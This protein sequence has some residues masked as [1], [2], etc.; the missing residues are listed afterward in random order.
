MVKLVGILNFTPDSF[1]D[2]G[3]FYDVDKAMAQAGKLFDDGA[4]IVDIGGEST[5]PGATPLAADEEWQRH[6]ETAEHA[7]RLGEVIINDVTGMN[8]ADMISVVARY[9][10][11]CI[12]SHLPDTDIQ[13][14]HK[15]K[16]VKGSD[17]VIMDL[18]RREKELAAAGIPKDHIIFD[19]GIG[20]GKTQEL[21]VELLEFAGYFP[22]REVMIGYSK[23]SFLGEEQYDTQVNLDAGRIAIAAG[24]AYLR[25][26]DVAAHRALL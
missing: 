17:T 9:G 7:L 1:S 16:D 13:T 5:R 10:A 4:S 15:L 21:N 14:A 18:M 26:H 23:K 2:K 19:P 12:V 3:R 22:G 11:R 6:P 8:N 20:F 24:A 25:V